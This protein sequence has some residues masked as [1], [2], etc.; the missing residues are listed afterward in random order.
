MRRTFLAPVHAIH[1]QLTRPCGAASLRER[2]EGWRKRAEE[3][4]QREAALQQEKAALQTQLDHLKQIFSKKNLASGLSA[5]LCVCMAV[6]CVA[7]PVHSGTHGHAAA[8]GGSPTGR[9]LL[10][11]EA[12]DTTAPAPG[13]GA[14]LPQAIRAWLDAIWESWSLRA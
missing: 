6:V 10:S 12:A 13:M 7:L 4:K 3:W 11:F 1:T 14:L 2:D 8:A 5:T 9:S